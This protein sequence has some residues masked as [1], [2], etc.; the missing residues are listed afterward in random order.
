MKT[1]LHTDWTVAD[2][3][4]GFVFDRNEGKGLFG[5]DGQLVIQPEYQRNYIYGD[6]KRDV[7]VV[8]SLLRDSPIGLLYFVRNDDGK[9]EVLDG[10]QRITS[11]AR[12]VNTSSP[13]AVDRGGKPRYF[14][15]LDVMS[16][17]VVESVE[18]YAANRRVVSVVVVEVEPAG[19][20][21]ASFGL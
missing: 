4:K 3:S 15:S 9:Y 16:R 11:F 14:D 10:Q 1:E 18:G 5:M 13:F 21:Q 19:Q 6:G 20:R 7:A 8:D 17:D 2:I 12:F